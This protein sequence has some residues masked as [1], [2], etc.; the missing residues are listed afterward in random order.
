MRPAIALGKKE[1]PIGRGDDGSRVVQARRRQVDLESLRALAAR[2]S[3]DA[4]PPWIDSQRTQ[5]R[6]ASANPTL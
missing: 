6:T 3:P 1:I 5:W 2:R 4:A